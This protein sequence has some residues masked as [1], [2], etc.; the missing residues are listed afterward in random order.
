MTTQNDDAPSAQ[1]LFAKAARHHA[2]QCFAEALEGYRAV[3]DHAPRHETVRGNLLLL[4]RDWEGACT[5]MADLDVAWRL[6]EIGDLLGAHGWLGDA[7]ESYERAFMASADIPDIE[8]RSS[9]HRPV[10][11]RSPP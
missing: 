9:L 3:L 5:G 2:E 6:M 8:V 7:G 1:E 10:D 4:R 11:D